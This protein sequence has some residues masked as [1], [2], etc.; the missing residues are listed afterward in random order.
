MHELY[1]LKKPLAVQLRHKNHL[2]PFEDET[3]LVR[4]SRKFDSSLLLFG[5]NSKKHP[6]S[7]IFARTFDY[8]LLDMVELHVEKFVSSTEFKNPG[9]VF[10]VK[11]S[12][13]LQG[14]HFESDETMKRV[15]NL[16]VDWFRGSTTNSVRLQGLELVVCLT[17]I[18][19]K[20][21]LLRTYRSELK[22]EVGSQYP[23]VELVEMGPNIDFSLG[24]NKLASDSLF[25]TSL[26]KPVFQMPSG[27]KKVH[28]DDFGNR[29]AQIHT[30]RQQTDAI[31][32][33]KVKA[34]KSGPPR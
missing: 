34:L 28:P 5:F 2:L 32:T 12:I 30:G 33:R 3:G 17:A 8:E 23:K 25:K 7:L 9:T 16:M 24:R 22:K 26:K 11:P 14:T 19:D 10:G 6:N 4:F 27:K 15:G 21:M 31:Q 13:I 18:S 29:V 1:T 20:K